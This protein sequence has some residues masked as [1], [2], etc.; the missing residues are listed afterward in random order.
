MKR[1]QEISISQE[2]FRMLHELNALV[3]QSNRKMIRHQT[4]ERLT[5]TSHIIII[6]KNLENKILSP[7][8]YFSIAK[9]EK[10]TNEG[11]EF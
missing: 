7:K 1:F 5:D 2:K 10:E 4:F 3:D 9:I 8:N 6:H 11:L